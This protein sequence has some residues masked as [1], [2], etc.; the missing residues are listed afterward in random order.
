MA[1][2]ATSFYRDRLGSDSEG[3]PQRQLSQGHTSK[4]KE[5][6]LKSVVEQG[7]PGENQSLK[8]RRRK[9]AKVYESESHEQLDEPIRHGTYE[10]N[11]FKFKGFQCIRQW[12]KL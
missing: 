8:S 1:N 7:S 3:D 12:S 5:R 4:A 2:P 10:D 11:L 9:R 6:Y